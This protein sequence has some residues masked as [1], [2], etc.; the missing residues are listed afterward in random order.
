MQLDG[1][2]E[3]VNRMR[4]GMRAL[5]P[6][7]I[8]ERLRTEAPGMQNAGMRAVPGMQ[9]MYATNVEHWKLDAQKPTFWQH[10]RRLL[11]RHT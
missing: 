7:E 3:A 1:E 11:R 5:T 10:L 6:D 9:N 8:S 4:D 2:R